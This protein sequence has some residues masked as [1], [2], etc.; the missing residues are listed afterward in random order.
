MAPTHFKTEERLAAAD[1]KAFKPV[2]ASERIEILD[3]LRGFALLGIIV[4]NMLTFSGYGWFSDAQM[5]ALP[6]YH[7][8]RIVNALL[9]IFIN[10]KFITIFSI[11]FGFG[12]SLQLEK[13]KAKNIAFRGYF[14]RRM[15]LLF[16]IGCGHAYLLWFGDI[17][18]YYALIGLL[19]I[20]LSQWSDKRI[21]QTS[22]FFLVVVTPVIFILNSIFPPEFLPD[23]SGITLQ[24][25]IVHAFSQ[26]SYAEVWRLNWKIDPIHNFLQ[27]SPITIASM[28]G[29]ILLG[30][31]LGRIGLFSRWKQH[32]LLFKKGLW[33][34]LCFGVPCSI[35]FWTL[36][37]GYL[38]LDSLWLLWIPFVVSGG[39]VMHSLFYISVF[40]KVYQIRNGQKWL[41]IF[42]PV[43]RM[44]LSNYVE[45]TILGLL[46]FYGLGLV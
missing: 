17:L 21:L 35:A 45:Q 8:D 43:G 32:E 22:L 30:V 38:N 12:F 19:I 39:L 27:D 34:G 16:V 40:V 36:H 11:L 10:T 29:K 3:A 31:W 41:R 25:R 28:I 4:I 7:T 18:R 14:A 23:A 26:G 44:A 46:I 9:D 5:R 20:P 24:Q 33:W 13:A 15:L 37:A 1:N 2:E 6:T 42:V